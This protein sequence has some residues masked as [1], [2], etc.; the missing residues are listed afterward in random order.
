MNHVF[1]PN[2]FFPV[3]D[4]TDVSPFMNATD[5]LQ[6]SLPW[7][8]LGDMSIACGRI[9]AG[10][11]SWIHMHPVVTHV[12][13]VVSGELCVRMKGENDEKPYRL[14]L[15]PGKA[16][17]TQP[18]TLFQL[19]NRSKRAVRV[20]Y[21]ASPSYVFEMRNGEVVYDDAVLVGKTWQEAN[22]AVA[23]L[24]AQKDEYSSERAEAL[25]RLGRLKQPHGH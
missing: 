9:K 7:G 4:G 24:L 14:E 1:K 19:D 6:D 17:L 20:L 8:A 16:V 21:I 11:K 3:P 25:E 23:R 5:N 2:K 10:V 15:S 12:T 18:G 22:R 13:Y